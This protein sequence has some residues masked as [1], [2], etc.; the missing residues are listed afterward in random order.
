[1]ENFFDAPALAGNS[2]PPRRDR[3]IVRERFGSLAARDLSARLDPGRVL[4]PGPSY[5]EARRIWNG[6]VEHRASL[7]SFKAEV[8]DPR[9]NCIVTKI[10][11][12]VFLACL[13]LAQSGAVLR[14]L[15]LW[16]RQ[17]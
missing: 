1:L 3:Q 16:A 13:R 11:P 7:S 9:Q 14:L 12:G 10:H 15:Q 8:L 5:D 2:S 6:A 4:M 17:E